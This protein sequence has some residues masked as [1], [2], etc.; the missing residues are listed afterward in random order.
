MPCVNA[1]WLGDIL[2][3]NFE[4][5]RQLHYGRYTTFNLQEPFA[6]TPH[7]VLNLLGKRAHTSADGSVQVSHARPPPSLAPGPLPAACS[8]PARWFPWVRCSR[9]PLTRCSRTGALRA[10]SGRPPR[11][12][13]HAAARTPS[14]VGQHCLLPSALA[15]Q[16][17]ARAC[18]CSSWAALRHLA[19]YSRKC[20][21]RQ[22]PQAV[23]KMFIELSFLM[24]RSQVKP[25]S[26][27]RGHICPFDLSSGSLTK[28][29]WPVLEAVTAGIVQGGV[30]VLCAG[31]GWPG[32]GFAL[33][34][35]LRLVLELLAQGTPV[36]EP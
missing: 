10:S 20:P 30:L 12:P 13:S 5:L 34:P 17:Q 18:G 9:C 2:L 33:T 36:P 7:L 1:Q 35:L 4:A 29:L 23:S 31:R 16:G 15:G 3:G 11:Q 28:T 22:L 24:A 32:R 25:Q 6:P 8:F 14:A 26:A 27:S 21:F 19:E